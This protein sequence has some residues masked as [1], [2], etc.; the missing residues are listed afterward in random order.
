[1]II[2]LLQLPWF[3]SYINPLVEL[4]LNFSHSSVEFSKWF[5]FFLDQMPQLNFPKTIVNFDKR[6]QCAVCRQ[7]V[8]MVGR[9]YHGIINVFNGTKIVQP[10]VATAEVFPVLFV[11]LLL[12]MLLSVQLSFRLFCF[13]LSCQFETTFC[14]LHDSFLRPEVK[15]ELFVS[16][17]KKVLKCVFHFILFF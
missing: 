4:M 16:F 14:I 9:S 10:A 2:L 15:M 6:M 8:V 3:Y 5:F 1:M 12:S 17:C 11:L 13:G 7:N